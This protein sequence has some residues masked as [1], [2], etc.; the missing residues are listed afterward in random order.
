MNEKGLGEE[1]TAKDCTVEDYTDESGKTYSK[2]T[3]SFKDLSGFEGI[4]GGK[5]VEDVYNSVEGTWHNGE[6]YGLVRV[7]FKA[8]VDPDYLVQLEKDTTLTNK[9]ILTGNPDL[10]AGGVSATGSVTIPKSASAVMSKSQASTAAPAYVQFALDINT[11][12]TDLVSGDYLTI[13]DVMGEGMSMAT[14]YQDPA[15]DSSF[16]A[17]YAVSSSVTDITGK[18][19]ISDAQKGTP[20]TDLCSWE[21]VPGTE[22]KYR[23]TVPDGKH[24]VIVYWAAFAGI[25]GQK[26]DLTNTAYFSY[27]GNDYTN[28]ESAWTGKVLVQGAGAGAYSNPYFY[29]QKQD[30]WGNNVSGALFGVYKYNESSGEWDILV[31]SRETK[32]GLAYIGHRT[33][34][35]AGENDTF[36]TLTSNTI[37]MIKEIQAATGYTLDS[38]EH[39]FEFANIDKITDDEGNEVVT[40]EALAA[41]QATHKGIA[42]VDL[43][44]GGT[45]TVTNTFN[46][47]SFTV[48]VVKTINGKDLSSTTEFS[49]TL[50]PIDSNEHPTYTD[51]DYKVK[52]GDSG[53]QTTIT[54]AGTA[55][56]A[57]LY[58][59]YTGEYKFHV[60][61]NDLSQAALS[62]GYTVKDSTIYTLTITVGVEDGKIAVTGATFTGGGKSGDLLD[63]GQIVFNNQLSLT[64]TLALQVKKTVSGRSGDVAENEFAF[65]VVNN[66]SVVKDSDGNDLVFK[67][68]AGGMVNINIPLTQDDIGTQYYII[69]EIVPDK[70]DQEQSIE[71]DAAPV[72][73][74]VTIGEVSENG[75]A[76]VA[77]TSTVAYT[78]AK[79]DS[80]VPLMVNA[81]KATG[82]LTLTGTKTMTQKGT[83]QTVAVKDDQFSFTVKEGNTIITTGTT[84]A[85]GSIVFDEI[86]YIQRDVGEHIYTIT[87]D[88]GDDASVTYD[89]HTA[90]VVVKVTDN[91]NGT[92]AA[93][94]DEDNSDDIAFNNVYTLKLI[95]TGINLDILPYL[96]ILLLAGFAGLL[97]LLRGK[98]RNG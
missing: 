83:D 94:V 71:Y 64:G 61:E 79:F 8:T 85:D 18:V 91:G 1:V 40:A 19:I 82:K 88:T 10:P 13:D 90:T 84:K 20:I 27:G 76:K 62:H 6:A 49:F 80:G 9:A 2:V 48:P 4:S 26:V 33:D 68:E 70:A 67:T 60:T 34:S 50:K 29:L 21:A 93:A 69:R 25:E 65:E 47:D 92:L 41:H 44:P 75:T 12:G 43:V 24:V 11:N 31:S 37:Y 97:P 39:Y 72:I 45:Y 73:A 54:G 66:G 7:E 78:A 52:L 89:T 32:D 77:A 5:L 59:K 58:F 17:V 63:K 28:N 55:F 23:F 57:P 30:Q 38:T 16:F 74:K 98:K 96:L 56:F 14:Q 42:V 53:I 3:L 46:G 35:T 81:Y 51:T 15:M 36:A 95:A 86:T 22:N 87:E